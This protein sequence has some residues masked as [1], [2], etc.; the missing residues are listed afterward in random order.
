[1][2]GFPM[3]SAA[4]HARLECLMRRCDELV[5]QGHAKEWAYTLALMEDESGARQQREEN[6]LADI[7][8]GG[9]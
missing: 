5:A 1:M 6:H 8:E 3:Y 4:A 2:S 9:T 7:R